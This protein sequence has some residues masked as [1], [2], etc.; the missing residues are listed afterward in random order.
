M[1]VSAKA[2]YAIKAVLESLR[3]TDVRPLL[4]RIVTPTLVLHRRDAIGR[5]RE[6][7]RRGRHA[8]LSWDRC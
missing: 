3:D 5:A 6:P 1:R 2:E 4:S 7:V 8:A